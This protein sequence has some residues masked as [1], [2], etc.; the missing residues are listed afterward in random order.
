LIKLRSKAFMDVNRE[1]DRH[2][3]K[4]VFG[5]FWKPFEPHAANALKTEQKLAV[6]DPRHRTWDL[7]FTNHN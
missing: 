4:A 7:T 6:A 1:A 3:K 2:V 5:V